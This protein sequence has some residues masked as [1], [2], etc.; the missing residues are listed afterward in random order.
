MKSREKFLAG[1]FRTVVG[2]ANTYLPVRPEGGVRCEGQ[3]PLEPPGNAGARPENITAVH[4]AAMVPR[5]RRP[6]LAGAWK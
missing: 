4:F 1:Q 3:Y 6:P 5:S 2:A